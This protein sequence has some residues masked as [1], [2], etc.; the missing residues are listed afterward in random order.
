MKYFRM[1]MTAG[2]LVAA[3]FLLNRTVPQAAPAATAYPHF[4]V[5][6][7]W[8][9]LPND[10]VLG[11]TPGVA[12]DRHDN[13]WIYNRPRLLADSLKSHAGPPVI[14]LDANGK[15]VTGWGGPGPGYD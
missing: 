15:F 4:E 9:K 13:V 1:M 5:D 3:V 7:A 12:V 11:P 6:P 10:W 14:E 8:P 2:F